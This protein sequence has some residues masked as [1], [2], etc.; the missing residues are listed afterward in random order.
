M[1]R[2]VC[3]TKQL[4][5]PMFYCFPSLH[6]SL[7]GSPL[8]GHAWAAYNVKCLLSHQLWEDSRQAWGGAISTDPEFS[9]ALSTSS[10]YPRKSLFL[11]SLAR[12]GTSTRLR[13]MPTRSTSQKYCISDSD[14]LESN[15]ALQGLDVSTRCY[16]PSQK[17]LLLSNP[18]H[19]LIP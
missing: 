9:I 15:V 13:S 4:A 3:I 10:R 12:R 18:T 6:Q 19:P 7:V 8:P 11:F 14:W 1:E 16:N 2:K 17:G 5:T